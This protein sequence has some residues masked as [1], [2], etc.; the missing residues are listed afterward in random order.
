[1][2]T[3]AQKRTIERWRREVAN[4]GDPT[5][6]VVESDDPYQR[7]ASAPVQVYVDDGY[8]V[9]SAAPQSSPRNYNARIA[10]PQT[11]HRSM[12]PRASS[13]QGRYSRQERRAESPTRTAAPIRTGS[14]RSSLHPRQIVDEPYY[15]ETRQ[16][17]S[18]VYASQYPS[19]K[20]SQSRTVTYDRPRTR[21]VSPRR[22][23]L[24]VSDPDV[25]RYSSRPKSVYAA[26]PKTVVVTRRGPERG[27]LDVEER[28]R[29]LDIRDRFRNEVDRARQW[30]DQPVRR[31]EYDR[32]SIR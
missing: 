29:L 24:R 28:M 17:Q 25:A 26:Q 8:T 4:A 7:E 16:P 15:T 22:D 5:R 13:D 32:R 3:Y 1:M 11:V 20:T 2:A 9:R 31:R 23:T 19:T 12:A 18:S 27:S 10:E 30:T 21:I 6:T 14:R